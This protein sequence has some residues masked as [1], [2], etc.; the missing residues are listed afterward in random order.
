M[1]L[2]KKQ[3]AVRQLGGKARA[4]AFTSD[5]QRQAQAARSRESLAAAGA[6]GYQAL[7]VSHGAGFAQDKAAEWR[8]A[9][10]SALEQKMSGLL[11]ARGEAYERE[12]KLDSGLYVDFLLPARRAVIEADGTGWHRNGSHCENREALDQAKD[13]RVAALGYRVLR[14]NGRAFEIGQAAQLLDEFLES[15]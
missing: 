10:P 12:A 8:R 2:S 1:A 7:V 5:Y 4:K 3:I 11:D 14:V 9:N 6:L 15:R 13:A